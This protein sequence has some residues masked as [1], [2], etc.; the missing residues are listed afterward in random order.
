MAEF[1]M[2]SL[3]ADME[4]G[5]IIEWRVRPGDTVHRGDVVAVVDTEKS[6]IEVE[7]FQDGVVEALLV[8]PGIEVPV[9]TLLATLTPIGSAAPKSARR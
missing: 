2:P 7:V 6:D 5:T 1:R 8:E 3:G 9:G 4:V